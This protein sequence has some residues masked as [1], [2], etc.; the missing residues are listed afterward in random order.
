M[1]HQYQNVYPL[2]ANMQ[3]KLTSLR[4]VARSY[5][6][7]ASPADPDAAPAPNQWN[8]VGFT[9]DGDTGTAGLLKYY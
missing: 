2:D 7:S 8:Y 5:L 3:L 6:S 4:V 9:Y 1:E